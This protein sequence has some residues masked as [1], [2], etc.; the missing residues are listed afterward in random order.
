MKNIIYALFCPNRMIPVYIG[1]SH[2][3]IERPFE[4][5]K[6][7]LHSKKVNEWVDLIKKSDQSP[8]IVILENECP[9]ELLAAKECFWINHYISKGVFLLNIQ[10]VTPF[11][12]DSN[13]DFISHDDYLKDVRE[14]IFSRRKLL[15]LTQPSLAKK[16]G[17]GLRFVR[18]VEQGT[19]T[20]FNTDSLMK[21]LRCIGRVKLGI[22]LTE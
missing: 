11:S 4:H 5:I 7:R 6:E 13:M 19:K 15:K 12:L 18:D 17:V 14:Y 8:V 20:N 16:A 3:G 9:D 21:V 22:V 1:K 2:K 10:M